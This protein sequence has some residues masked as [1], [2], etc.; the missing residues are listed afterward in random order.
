VIR[1]VR[2]CAYGIRAEW[3]RFGNRATARRQTRGFQSLIN[4]KLERSLYGNLHCSG[5]SGDVE[6]LDAGETVHQSADSRNRS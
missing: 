6:V 3:I 4:I 1:V 5:A 2:K